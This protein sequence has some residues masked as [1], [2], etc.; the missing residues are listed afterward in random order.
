MFSDPMSPI[1]QQTPLPAGFWEYVDAIPPEQYDG[2]ECRSPVIERAYRDGSGQWDHLLLNTHDENVFMVVLI[3]RHSATVVG[4]HLL[5]L[6]I[7]YGLDS[8]G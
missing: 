2:Y 6:R 1:E 5:N 7:H 4:H 8:S 3:D